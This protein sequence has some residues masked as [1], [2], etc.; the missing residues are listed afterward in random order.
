MARHRCAKGVIAWTAV[1]NSRAA[2]ARVRRA[3]V[4]L[5]PSGS[6]SLRGSAALRPWAQQRDSAHLNL[7]RN[8]ATYVCS[9][10]GSLVWAID[11]G[12]RDMD[13]TD[14]FSKMVRCLE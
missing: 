5:A 12:G 6:T 11:R 7:M 13:G 1:W 10:N 3:A 14:F 8:G 2:R 4:A 9:F